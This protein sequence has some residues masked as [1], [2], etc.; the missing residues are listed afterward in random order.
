MGGRG[1]EA[2]SGASVGRQEGILLRPVVPVLQ[3]EEH[4]PETGRGEPEALAV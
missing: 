3:G 4:L 2:Y 1:S